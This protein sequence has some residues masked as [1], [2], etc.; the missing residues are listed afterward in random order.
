MERK[1][2]KE[3][4][5]DVEN[6]DR[7]KETCSSKYEV[8]HQIEEA[9]G[10]GDYRSA[11]RLFRKKIVGIL[12]AE[13]ILDV[14][15]QYYF[16]G[17]RL[18]EDKV[19]GEFVGA[20]EYY[21]ATNRGYRSFRP[22]GDSFRCGNAT[23]SFLGAIKEYLELLAENPGQDPWEVLNGYMCSD[24]F[25]PEN[26]LDRAGAYSF[27]HNRR[28]REVTREAL[29]S[30]VERG[31]GIMD[32]GEFIEWFE[33]LERVYTT[34]GFPFACTHLGWFYEGYD[35]LYRKI[36]DEGAW[37]L[38]DFWKQGVPSDWLK[39]QMEPYPEIQPTYEGVIEALLKPEYEP[40]LFRLFPFRLTEDTLKSGCNMDSD[41]WEEFTLKLARALHF[42]ECCGRKD[43]PDSML[44]EAL[45]ALE[46]VLEKVWHFG[47]RL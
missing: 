29:A 7:Y 41:E 14:V 3:A 24:Y 36:L 44:D 9:V 35:N 31:Y 34:H 6:K 46:E 23:A 21:F 22:H 15:S 40:L 30:Y 1:F 4:S 42:S 32:A 25:N 17:N 18:K 33:A 10:T 5:A 20:Y 28:S 13:K 47:N 43:L 37:M 12:Y 2:I 45:K 11:F 26:Y 16:R 8:I 39:N 27:P 19:I 38:R